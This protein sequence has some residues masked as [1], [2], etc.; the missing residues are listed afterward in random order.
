MTSANETIKSIDK[1]ETKISKEKL[2]DAIRK[3]NLKDFSFTK[4]ATTNF[5]A[6]VITL[7]S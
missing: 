5:A 7:Q 6:V 4:S 3:S 1:F 2:I